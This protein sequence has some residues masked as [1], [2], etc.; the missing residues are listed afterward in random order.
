MDQCVFKEI[1]ANHPPGTVLRA[2]GTLSH[3]IEGLILSHVPGEEMQLS[4]LPL[5]ADSKW[6]G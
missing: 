4:K 2:L 6:G 1:G 5:D 3:L